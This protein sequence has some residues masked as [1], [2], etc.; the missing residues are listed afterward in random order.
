M[1][2][3][4]KRKAVIIGILSLLLTFLQIAGWQI[5]MDYGSSVHQSDFFQK[6]GP[7]EPWQCIVWGILEF[8]FFCLF[9]YF[10]FSK[11]EKRQ[12]VVELPQFSRK[13][14]TKTFLGI[15]TWPLIFLVL[16][17]IWLFLLWGCFPGYYNY[18]TGNQ[19]VQ[20]L[21]DEVPYNAHHPL[22][23]TLFSGGLITLGYRIDSTN[24]VLGV[25]IVNAVQMFI[26]ALCFTYSLRF[27][28]RHTGNRILTLTAFIFYALCPTIVMFGM[29]PT[30]DVLCYSFLLV[31]VLLMYELI[32]KMNRNIP[33]SIRHWISL[34]GF[35]TLSC[36][37]RKNNVYA[38]IVFAVISVIMLRKKRILQVL[39]YLCILALY[40]LIDKSL[41]YA[42]DAIPGSVNEALCVPYQQIARLYTEKGEEAFTTE[43]LELLSAIVPPE[44]L[45][46][47]DP[48]MADEIKANFNPGLETLMNNK[49]TYL[50]LWIKKGLEYPGVYIDSILYNTHQAW[51]PGSFNV[52][53]RGVRYF[54]ISGWQDDFGAPNI[55]KLYEFHQDIS[56]CSFI[57]YPLIRLL[58]STGAMMWL[59]II[60]W[61]Y[62]IWKKDKC[63]IAPLLLVLLVCGTIFLGPI[64]DVR[65]FLILF[66]MLPVCMGLL[67]GPR[68]ASSINK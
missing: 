62:G 22:L 6:I 34:G 59:T 51:Y 29:C 52:I 31:A 9:F 42:L 11:L 55:P 25:F 32:E 24:L 19:L 16:Y 56:K 58:F 44:N 49:G 39:M 46:I 36:L 64:A 61:F 12:N 26:S 41:L 13:A 48:A 47:Y 66:Y 1:F 23:H 4:E 40:L 14:D 68:K 17:G 33:I 37:M 21:Y 50:K 54:D 8:T 20:V 67:F 7:L 53:R 18:D 28:Y 65:Y 5:S 27:I 2:K 63:I 15:L 35:L 3:L 57:K 30:K 43:E 10:L 38:L 60:T 45:Q